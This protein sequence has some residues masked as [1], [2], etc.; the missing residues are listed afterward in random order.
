VSSDAIVRGQALSFRPLAERISADVAPTEPL[1][2][3]DV[4]DEQAIQ[5]QY[6]LHRHVT[7]FF[8]GEG[9][10]PCAAP[11]PGAYLI[12]E[13]RWEAENCSADPRW[14]L[15]AR[16]G[17]EI[18]SSRSERLVFARYSPAPG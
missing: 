9:H 17:P 8:S 2:F 18:T 1:T 15:I 3:L 5:L 11:G 14:H 7:V 6:H 13:P 10:A 12:A 16:G 4:V